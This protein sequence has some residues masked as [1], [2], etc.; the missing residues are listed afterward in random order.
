MSLP[1]DDPDASLLMF[2]MLHTIGSISQTVSEFTQHGSITPESRHE[3]RLLQKHPNL[4]AAA[5]LNSNSKLSLP[6]IS[7]SAVY[8]MIQ[9]PPASDTPSLPSSPYHLPREATP[10]V[11]WGPAGADCGDFENSPYNGAPHPSSR[12]VL[13]IRMEAALEVGSSH[14]SNVASQRSHSPILSQTSIAPL[15]ASAQDSTESMDQ[16]PNPSH[17][18]AS[19]PLN[20]PSLLTISSE[21]GPSPFPPQGSIPQPNTPPTSHLDGGIPMDADPG[22]LHQVI[23][24]VPLPSMPS[25]TS[26]YTPMDADP[27]PPHLSSPI[28]LQGAASLPSTTPSGAGLS[29]SGP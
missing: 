19:P 29:P 25:T 27:A 16:D 7:Q 20:N 12:A 6:D 21:R 26:G 24:F 2:S 4:F 15:P 17:L 11:L 23:S 28:E 1:P 13:G 9:S 18:T 14:S 3:L 10:S 22:L 8:Q 5:T